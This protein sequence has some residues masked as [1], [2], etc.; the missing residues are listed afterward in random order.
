MRNIVKLELGILYWVIF[1]I[2]GYT[3]FIATDANRLTLFNNSTDLSTKLYVVF[4]LVGLYALTFLWGQIF[5]G[6]FMP[7]LR[8]LFG[9]FIFNF[10]QK[11]G[12]FAF[13]FATLHPLL[14]YI[15]YLNT[16]GS[17]SIQLALYDYLGE[18]LLIFG[19]LGIVA[20][21]FMAVVVLTAILRRF[22]YFWRVIHFLNY[23][24]F[25]LVM[26]HSLQI[27]S[28]VNLSPLKILYW[29]YAITFIAGLIYRFGYMRLWLKFFKLNSSLS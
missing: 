28:D 3:F 19:L 5:I 15:A 13:I 7:V 24:I 26:V 22:I 21:I 29:I 20:W 27:G 10:H 12:I 8:R 2:P 6:S 18:K 17:N 25:I 4:R 16:S 1:I 11:Q 9:V 23:L 14:F